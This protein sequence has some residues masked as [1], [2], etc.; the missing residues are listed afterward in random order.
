[1]G[2]RFSVK[3]PGE[4]RIFEELRNPSY[5]SITSST[6]RFNYIVKAR[7]EPSGSGEILLRK[8]DKVKVIKQSDDEGYLY[9][10]RLNEAK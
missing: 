5:N 3:K 6:Q 4:K 7:Y 2:N 1:M 8:G 9:V 10:E